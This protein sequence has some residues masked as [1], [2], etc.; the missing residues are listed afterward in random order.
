MNAILTGTALTLHN[1]G[2]AAGFGGSL[3]GQMAMHPAVKTIDDKKERGELLHQAWRNF[4]LANAFGLAAV[5][6][7]W[8]LGRSAL[9]GGEIDDK[10]RALVIAKDVLVGTYVATGA[11]SIGV[12][13][14]IGK[15]Q[16]PVEQGGVPAAETPERDATAIRAVNALGITNILAAAGIIALTAALNVKAGRSHRWAFLSK[17]LP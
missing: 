17:F 9:S 3:Y 1:M 15:D 6:L 4:S 8:L 13:M 10:T 12:G 7:T 16:P 5:G 2:L 14:A 11:A